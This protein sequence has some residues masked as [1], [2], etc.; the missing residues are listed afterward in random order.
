MSDDGT[1]EANT[2]TKGAKKPRAPSAAST[3]LAKFKT[4][5]MSQFGCP[6][7]TIV[8]FP[9]PNYKGPLAMQ[10]A[11]NL[12]IP[13]GM[14]PFTFKPKMIF[15]IDI[16]ERKSGIVVGWWK[17][18]HDP[19]VTLFD[20]NVNFFPNF[21]L[22]CE[23]L[24]AVF[25]TKKL[26]EGVSRW[27][28]VHTLEEMVQSD[29][30]DYKR[31]KDTMDAF[32]PTS[33]TG[34]SKDGKQVRADSKTLQA[35]RALLQLFFDTSAEK[36]Y[37]SNGSMNEKTFLKIK[38]LNAEE[39]ARILNRHVIVYAT[40]F[41]EVFG[42]IDL[43]LLE[44][45]NERFGEQGKRDQIV[46]E[47]A[48]KTVFPEPESKYLVLS[49]SKKMRVYPLDA[50]D[51]LRLNQQKMWKSLHF[52]A[53]GPTNTL[54]YNLKKLAKEKRQ[55]LEQAKFQ[56]V[57]GD[58]AKRE[59]ASGD[60]AKA[61]AT[62]PPPKPIHVDPSPFAIRAASQKQAIYVP[63]NFDLRVSKAVAVDAPKSKKRPRLSD[64]VAIPVGRP[65]TLLQKGV[66]ASLRL[67]QGLS[68]G[69]G[70]SL[71]EF[72]PP[73]KRTV[74]T[75][76][77]DAVVDLDSDQEEEED[78]SPMLLPW[79]RESVEKAPVPAPSSISSILSKFRVLE[80]K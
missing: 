42:T 3:S 66:D 46:T 45:Q 49:A 21:D 37:M 65:P 9:P 34:V 23:Y 6:S 70:D 72:E 41:K 13:L 43:F 47:L 29:V 2:N 58:D 44:E 76:F 24:H 11:A 69:E 53:L 20:E 15:S 52:C 78:L 54:V 73:A 50:V 56:D 33:L 25:G 35:K 30:D 79:Q 8:P 22:T 32:T 71:D 63:P 16:G 39:K 14:E 7:Q 75:Q 18:P 36:S 68:D 28:Q 1:G 80:P 67:L 19:L 61:V 10:K 74:E 12:G 64:K 77:G 31:M 4:Q 40:Y 26:D 59:G 17:S 62:Q 5:F 51:A 27:D 55:V 60:K 48:L 57:D 38:D